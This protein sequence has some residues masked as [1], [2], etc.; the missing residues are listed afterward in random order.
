MEHRRPRLCRPMSL[1]PG[2][3]DL[4]IAKEH[5]TAMNTNSSPDPQEYY[6]CSESVF[7]HGKSITESSNPDQSV[8]LENQKA[9]ATVFFFPLAIPLP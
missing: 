8:G 5:E 3:L 4:E 6:G 7:P 9:E 1:R 2:G